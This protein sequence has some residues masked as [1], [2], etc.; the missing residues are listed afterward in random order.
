L[1]SGCIFWRIG[2]RK[3]VLLAEGNGGRD[4]NEAETGD[5]CGDVLSG[6]SCSNG[7]WKGWDRMKSSGPVWLD[8]TGNQSLLL[9]DT[10]HPCGKIQQNDPTVWGQ[11][12]L[13][14]RAC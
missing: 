12:L 13:A 14:S 4:H 10:F 2:R 5:V 3:K 7:N 6:M 11:H 9:Q 8:R 1:L